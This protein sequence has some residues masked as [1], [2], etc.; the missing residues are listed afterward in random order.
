MDLDC[1]SCRTVFAPPDFLACCSGYVPSADAM[2]W[3]CARCG[4]RVDVRV[5]DD[6]VQRG[7]VYGAGAAHFSDEHHLPLPGVRAERDGD[8]LVIRFGGEEWRV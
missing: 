3:I 1:L 2:A 5:V 6:E 7:Y 8:T 4:D